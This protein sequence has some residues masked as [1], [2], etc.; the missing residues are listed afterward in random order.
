MTKV[1]KWNKKTY[2]DAQIVVEDWFYAQTP[3]LSDNTIY[4][5][6]PHAKFRIASHHV[7]RSTIEEIDLDNI[8]EKE[9]KH[10]EEISKVLNTALKEQFADE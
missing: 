6:S 1:K 8:Y 4:P 9:A 3:D 5:F 10:N 2:I 7:K